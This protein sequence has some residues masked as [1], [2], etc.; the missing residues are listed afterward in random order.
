MIIRYNP[1]VVHC[2]LGILIA[3]DGSMK[4]QATKIMV[5]ARK[6]THDI[7]KKS[8]TN[9]ERWMGYKSVLLPALKYPLAAHSF[10]AD[11]LHTIQSKVTTTIRNALHLN[12]SFPSAIFQG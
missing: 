5:M 10:T 11:S 1:F 3:P 12:C 9:E 2:T 6:W 7:N 8:L 4:A